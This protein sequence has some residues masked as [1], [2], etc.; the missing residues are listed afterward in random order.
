MQDETKVILDSI[1]SVEKMSDILNGKWDKVLRSINWMNVDVSILLELYELVIHELLEND[2]RNS[3]L[4]FMNHITKDTDKHKKDFP[5]RFKIIQNIIE[6]EI[7]I[8]DIYAEE[9]ST[10]EK[11]IINL[12]DKLTRNPSMIAPNIL[13]MLISCGL[14]YLKLQKE[15]LDL[16]YLFDFKN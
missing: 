2:E 6:C 8:E 1:E 15:I 14:K 12:A 4:I 3:A 16:D 5:Q 9:K 13:M 11:N 7:S 10:K